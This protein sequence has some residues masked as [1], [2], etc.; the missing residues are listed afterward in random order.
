MSASVRGSFDAP[1]DGETIGPGVRYLT[2]WSMADRVSAPV[3]I[4]IDG[5]HVAAARLGLPRPDVA[6]A[7]CDPHAGLSGWQQIL[8]LHAYAAGRDRLTVEAVARAPD[9]TRT[10]IGSVS[11]RIADGRSAPDRVTGAS[12]SSRRNGRR[13]PATP[14]AAGRPLRLLALTHS[15]DGGGSQLIL[16][17]RLRELTER[18]VATSAVVSPADGPLRTDFE[19]AG[20]ACKLVD[21]LPPSDEPSYER[22]LNQ[23]TSWAISRGFD[24]VVANTIAASAAIDLADRLGL[25]SIWMIYETPVS[26]A[27]LSPH[28]SLTWPAFALDQANRALAMA[29]AVVFDADAVRRM[30]QHRVPAGRLVTIPG[31]IDLAAIEAFRR[32]FNR[33][34]SRHARGIKDHQTLV[35]GLGSIFLH[36][37]YP[38]LAEVFGSLA[39]DIPDAVLVL[40]GGRRDRLSQGI[41]TYACECGLADRL[42]VEPFGA[43]AYDWLGAADLFVSGSDMESMPRVVLEAMAFEVPIVATSVGDVPTL[44][45]HGRTGWSI[46]PNDPYA[47]ANALRGALGSSAG[48]RARVTAAAAAIVSGRDARDAS[49]AFESLVCSL[50]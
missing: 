3:E 28:L 18:G 49:R 2:G 6:A 24:L 33:V 38:L 12:P 42:R 7:F 25:P 43:G 50:C 27:H 5:R 39:P 41:E 1:A 14:R 11:L 46:P 34:S 13:A 36:K 16:L 37:G 19:R 22:H 23:L 9:G 48:E 26:P 4:W 20:I 8:D 17:E 32:T 29:S 31:A 21:W 47:W 44:V 10:T 45:E 15:L 35:L 30:Y 40:V